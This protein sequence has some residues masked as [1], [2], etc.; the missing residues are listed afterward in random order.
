MKKTLLTAGIALALGV[1]WTA[2][3]ALA[4]QTTGEKAKDKAVETK[5]TVKEK[6]VD[7]K[8]TVKEKAVEAKDKIKE[9]TTELKDKA[10]AKMDRG[11]AKAEKKAD[12]MAAKAES[13]DVMA[14][15]QALKDKG[16]DPGP[17]DGVMGPRTQAALKDYQQKE[18]LKATGRWDDATAAKLGVRMSEATQTSDPAASPGTPSVPPKEPSD[19]TAPAEKPRRPASP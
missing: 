8:D 12:R 18:G 5:D 3:P 14:M 13:K 6:A 4:Q 10:K 19:K 2:G 17:I 9:K 1:V 15:Q 16:H 11:E 7:A